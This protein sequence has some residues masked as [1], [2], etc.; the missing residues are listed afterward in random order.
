MDRMS[1]SRHGFLRIVA[2]SVFDSCSM[3][4]FCEALTSLF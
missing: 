3:N 2:I 4:S 1:V